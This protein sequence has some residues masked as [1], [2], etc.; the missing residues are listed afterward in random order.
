[1][2]SQYLALVAD[3]DAAVRVAA[4]N[5]QVDGRTGLLSDGRGQK[6]WGRLLYKVV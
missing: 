3:L 2:K 6:G 1:M 4:M 5:E